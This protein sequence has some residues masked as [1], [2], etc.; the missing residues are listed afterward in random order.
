MS[1]DLLLEPLKLRGWFQSE[2]LGEPAGG[3]PVDVERVGLP[4]GAVQRHHQLSTEPLAERIASQQVAELPH[5]LGRPPG[6][7]LG[8]DPALQGRQTKLLEPGDRPPRDYLRRQIRQRS[9]SPDGQRF[10]EF[11]RPVQR[12]GGHGSPGRIRQSFEA[13]DVEL[14]WFDQH[15]IATSR[16]LEAPGG[17]PEQ[18][19]DARDVDLDALHRRRRGFEPQLVDQM[20]DRHRPIGLQQEDH[21]ERLLLR[22]PQVQRRSGH[23]NLERAQEPKGDRGRTRRRERTIRST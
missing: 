14:A 20:V 17:L 23:A 6:R 2:L 12:G 13:I 7:Q 21:Q 10:A 18:P 22:G 8:V 19:A 11:R 3:L 16:G 4:A 5:D 9:A 15:P 1:K